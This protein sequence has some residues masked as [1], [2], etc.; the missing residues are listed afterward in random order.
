MLP[1][2][3]PKKEENTSNGNSPIP[4]PIPAAFYSM[5]REVWGFSE[6]RPPQHAA[7]AAVLARKDALVVMPTGGGK[8]LCYQ[9]P[10]LYMGGLTIVV[11][12]LI[13]LMKDQVDSLH[14]VGVAAIRLDSSLSSQ[15]KQDTARALKSGQTRLLFV[16]PERL[17]NPDF[18]RFLEGTPVQNIAI[19]EAHCVSQWGHDF[20]PEY[21]QLGSLRSSFPNAAFQ[22]FTATATEKVQRDIVEQL[23]LISPRIHVSSFDRPNLTYRVLP[24][25]DV[26]EQIREVCTRHRGSGGIVYCLRRA[27]VEA[28]TLYLK[29]HGFSVAA[30][31][32]GMSNNDRKLSQ[33]AFLSESVDVVVATVA[34]GMGIDRSNVRYVI[35]ASVPKSIEHYQQET[36]RAGR[37][38]LP[39]ECVLFYSLAD[40]VALKR[41]TE[42]SL[43][44]ANASQ[45]IIAASRHQMDEL[46]RYCQSPVCRHRALVEYFGQPYTAKSCG[47]CDHCLGD[48][49][50]IDDAKVI[51][52]KILSCVFRVQ[53]R[54][55]VNYVVSIL[56]GARAQNITQRG[57]DKLSTY[58][59]LANYPINQIRDWVYQLIGQGAVELEG[60]EYPILKLN[61]LS[62][63]ILFRDASP[64]LIKTV[65]S[66]KAT[67]QS[68]GSREKSSANHDGADHALFERLRVLRRSLANEQHVPPYMVFSDN[69]LMELA[70]A[71]PSTPETMMRITGIG[72]VK[73]K[74]YGVQVLECIN[75]Y[76]DEK[77]VAT[78]VRLKSTPLANNASTNSL[79]VDVNETST[80]GTHP[81]S[82][83]RSRHKEPA[84]FPMLRRGVAID[85]I[86][87]KLE[88]SPKT[89]WSHLQQLLTAEPT[90]SISPWVSDEVRDEVVA[91]GFRVGFELLKPIYED[92][93]QRVSYEAIRTVLTDYQNQTNANNAMDG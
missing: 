3:S 31:H 47:A 69:T 46:S 7:I 2:N 44:E 88:L 37:D 56:H 65:Q 8:S 70:A 71:R 63:E 9:A 55:G 33:D 4:D 10:A 59:L 39:A 6:L 81:K 86:A 26:L 73:M 32:A 83:N 50:S 66:S 14:Q 62:R 79:T 13:A 15:E 78:D 74:A 38:G 67:R 22:A 41:I 16:S 11:S 75:K 77:Q 30:Y 89:I 60:T 92:L 23:A 1:P 53:E 58:G 87:S 52:Q 48:T 57:H 35:H 93:Q 76:C 80:N 54:F 42:T 24:Q 49:Q 17:C 29:K 64:R 61:A 43:T 82:S 51:A 5:L 91:S 20:R 40:V 34:F 84:S 85:D 28:T 72:S 36:G 25:L 90:I 27:D 19:D 18:I 12:P 21:R 45:E 68:K